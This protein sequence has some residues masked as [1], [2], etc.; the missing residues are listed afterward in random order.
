VIQLRLEGAGDVLD[1]NGIATYGSGFQATT[2]L[3]GFGL[4]PVTAQWSEGAG[5]G[6]TYRGRRVL[7]RDIDIPLDI[8]ATDRENLKGLMSRLARVLA[9]EVKIVAVEPDGT[10]WYTYG[11]R[12]GGG[13]FVYG[14][15]T[16]GDTDAQVVITLRCGDPYFTSEAVFRERIIPLGG[17]SLFLNSMVN[18]SVS[19]SSVIGS[20]TIDNTGDATV[21][22]V[23]T[24]VGPGDNFKAVSPS[25]ETLWWTGTLTAG[26]T[27]T[28]DTRK[29]TVV[30]DTGVNKYA[31]LAAAPRFWTVAPG[32]STSEASFQ[33]TTS[34][35]LISCGWRI[36]KWLVI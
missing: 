31:N 25:G 36:R 22:P 4:P 35:S 13:Q 16:I 21:Y 30:S 34:G 10:E 19:P 20:I 9:G 6:A 1:L 32:I 15:D 27:L 23:W 3:T 17:T 12:V 18:L 33:G 24:V 5:D 28:I 26:Q 7:A 8:L 11:V 14:K 2:G 29:G